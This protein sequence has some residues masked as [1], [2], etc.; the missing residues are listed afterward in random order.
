MQ[1]DIVVTMIAS[2]GKT[3]KLRLEK[4]IIK[5]QSILLE[6]LTFVESINF[7]QKCQ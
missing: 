6:Y 3:F 4:G 2:Q 7:L 5:D 1:G